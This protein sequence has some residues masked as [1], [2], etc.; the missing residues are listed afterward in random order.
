MNFFLHLFFSNYWK[1]NWKWS[2]WI[3]KWIYTK[4]IRKIMWFIPYIRKRICQFIQSKTYVKFQDSCFRKITPLATINQRMI[5]FYFLGSFFFV[6][7]SK[8]FEKF[9]QQLFLKLPNFFDY[10]YNWFCRLSV[11]NIFQKY[12]S[13][14]TLKISTIFWFWKSKSNFIITI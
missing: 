4:L 2:K 14:F 8:L 7:W 6:L 9:P 3:M 5:I 10:K 13:L 12:Q 11:L 1:D